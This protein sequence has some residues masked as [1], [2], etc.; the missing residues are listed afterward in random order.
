MRYN[1][2]DKKINKILNLRSD[3]YEKDVSVFNFI[4]HIKYCFDGRLVLHRVI[5]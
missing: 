5:K 2:N 1:Y 4:F 3:F